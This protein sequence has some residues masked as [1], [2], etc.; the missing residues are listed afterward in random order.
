MMEN[1]KDYGRDSFKKSY[2]YD[3]LTH[4]VSMDQ[5]HKLNPHEVLAQMQKENGL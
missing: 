2:A 3:P 1:T 4:G 5:L